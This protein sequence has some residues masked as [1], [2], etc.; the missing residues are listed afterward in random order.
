MATLE[1]DEDYEPLMEHRLNEIPLTI[2]DETYILVAAF[3]F[4]PGINLQDIGHYVTADRINERWEMYDNLKDKAVEMSSQKS[5]VI[6]SL[7]YLKYNQNSNNCG[8]TSSALS[9]GRTL[10]RKKK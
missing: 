6:Q 5:V 2:F 4:K 8:E 9:S 7:L 3:L 10:R 1:S